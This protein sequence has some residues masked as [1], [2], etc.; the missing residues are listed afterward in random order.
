VAEGV[1]LNELDELAE[2]D[3]SDT[4]SMTVMDN[5]YVVKTGQPI[6]E[7]YLAYLKDKANGM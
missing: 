5:R 6:I 1:A 7:Q 2:A 3:G 4:D